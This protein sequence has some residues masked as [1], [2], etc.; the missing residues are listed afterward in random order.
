MTAVK[1]MDL[2]VPVPPENKIY[3]FAEKD[4]GAYLSQMLGSAVAPP[5]EVMRA[6]V[7]ALPLQGGAVSWSYLEGAGIYGRWPIEAA[8]GRYVADVAPAPTV[9]VITDKPG[10]PLPI[11]LDAL[12]AD[13]RHAAAV[14]NDRGAQ[15][16]QRFNR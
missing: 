14:T 3:A 4:P 1:E 12:E 7:Q 9:V 13:A 8:V 15:A 6:R 5:Q 2:G 10:K 16:G 11:D